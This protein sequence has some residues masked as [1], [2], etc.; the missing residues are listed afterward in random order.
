MYH[1]ASNTPW[2]H[3]RIGD[4]FKRIL[5]TTMPIRDRV[6]PE[7]DKMNKYHFVG[8]RVVLT[9]GARLEFACGAA[10]L[11]GSPR[12]VAMYYDDK[13]HCVAMKPSAGGQVVGRHGILVT[14]FTR[15]YNVD[16]SRTMS[17]RPYVKDG[18][19]MFNLTAGMPVAE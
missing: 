12:K 14:R 10:E 18:C 2:I 9:R 13:T 7:I 6:G 16:C 8:P 15:Q 17:Y 1:C 11:I 3:H 5:L 19:L 4:S